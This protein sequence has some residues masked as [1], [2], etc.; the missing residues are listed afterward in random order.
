MINRRGHNGQLI[1][2][3][4]TQIGLAPD[5]ETAR[6]TLA[7]VVAILR[8]RF[9]LSAI[10]LDGSELYLRR[11]CGPHVDLMLL[12]S[13]KDLESICTRHDRRRYPWPQG[14]RPDI[15]RHAYGPIVDVVRQVQEWPTS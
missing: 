7:I 6:A 10:K 9:R 4:E 1:V 8:L 2:P 3:F 5:P 14:T 15:G 13:D 11:F 12:R